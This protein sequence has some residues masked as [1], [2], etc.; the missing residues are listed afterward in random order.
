[1]PLLILEQY[2]SSSVV[3]MQPMHFL[4]H[5]QKHDL[6]YWICVRA[7]GCRASLSGVD[8]FLLTIGSQNINIDERGKV[9]MRTSPSTFWRCSCACNRVRKEKTEFGGGDAFALTI[10]R[11]RRDITHCLLESKSCY[12]FELTTFRMRCVLCNRMQDGNIDKYPSMALGLSSLLQIQASVSLGSC[13]SSQIHLLT[14]ITTSQLSLSHGANSQS[15]SRFTL[16]L[17]GPVQG[18]VG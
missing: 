6:S 15:Q 1:M 14:W 3:S 2:L 8:T 9:V 18:L 11:K 12:A 16:P 5:A 7:K 4:H 10:N 13:S 17:S